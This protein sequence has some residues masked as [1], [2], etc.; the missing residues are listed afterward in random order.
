MILRPVSSSAEDHNKGQLDA[1]NLKITKIAKQQ[2]RPDRY[3]IYIDEKYS[4]SLSEYQL[5]GAKLFIGKQF[6]Q[7]ELT[8]FIDESAFGKAYERA[9]NYVMIRPRSKQEIQDYLKRTFLYPKPK[10]YVDKAGVRQLVKREV[11]KEKVESMIERVMARLDEKGYIN[12]MAFAR[13]WV[14]SRQ[15]TK[16]SSKRKLEQEL[17][18]K[19][20]DQ[21]IIATVLQNQNDTEVGNLKEVIIKKRR[22]SKY[23]DDVKLT[24]Y[25]LRQ[26]F[27]YDDIKEQIEYV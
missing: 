6:T 3:S 25:L 24:Q 9:L 23:Q 26:G 7:G 1:Q 12:D 15:L 17:R 2:K 16:K 8:S 10:N 21:E 20:I 14:N 5:A 19:F 13:A 18:A 22:L 11:D 27:N 4:F